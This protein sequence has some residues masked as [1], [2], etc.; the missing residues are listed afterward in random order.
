MEQDN[1]DTYNV[2]L[3]HFSHVCVIK[4]LSNVV[5]VALSAL[6]GDFIYRKRNTIQELN[7]KSEL[8]FELLQN[9]MEAKKRKIAL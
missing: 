4:R 6:V 7:G 1:Y 9:Q 8:R 3:Y 5:L 2:T